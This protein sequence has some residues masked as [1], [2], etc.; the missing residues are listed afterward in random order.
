VFEIPSAS[1]YPDA[2]EIRLKFV[3]GRGERGEAML[4]A[5]LVIIDGAMVPAGYSGGSLAAGSVILVG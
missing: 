3:F 1:I 5:A 2:P 4:G